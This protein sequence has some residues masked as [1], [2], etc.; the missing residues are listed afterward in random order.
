VKRKKN[1]IKI[2]KKAPHNE[3]RSMHTSVQASRQEKKPK[4]RFKEIGIVMNTN[5]PHL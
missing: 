4:Q 5:K 3:K 1:G 2:E